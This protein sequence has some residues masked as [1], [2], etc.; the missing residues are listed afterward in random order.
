MASPAVIQQYTG[1]DIEKPIELL[2]N[3][4]FSVLEHGHA[5]YNL[6][7]LTL[8]SLFEMEYIVTENSK[9]MPPARKMNVP[10]SRS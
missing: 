3:K 4:G 7:Y 1:L 5:S 8:A 6:T 2:R 9:R 10:I